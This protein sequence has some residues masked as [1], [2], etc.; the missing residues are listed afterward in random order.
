MGTI[1]KRADMAVFF[2]DINLDL[3]ECY[4]LTESKVVS[5]SSK[6]FIHNI[7]R[8]M[9]CVYWEAGSSSRFL[10]DSLFSDIDWFGLYLVWHLDLYMAV[11]FI[12]RLSTGVCTY[13]MKALYYWLFVAVQKC[14][15]TNAILV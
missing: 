12:N 1:N 8:S 11:G 14:F 15:T 5:D 7:F 3:N 2:E 9:Y 10:V 4:I 6:H 13:F